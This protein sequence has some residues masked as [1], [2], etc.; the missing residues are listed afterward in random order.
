VYFGTDFNDV[1]DAS[2]DNPMDVL[3]SE[4]QDANT[5]DPGLLEFG[6]TYYWRVDEVNAPPDPIVSKGDIWSFTVEPLAYKI[7][8]ESITATASSQYAD[9]RG[10]EN[11]INESGL[12]PN[13]LDLHSTE[14]EAMWLTGADDTAPV[15][16]QYEFDR[17]YKL[18]QMLVWNYNGEFVL[19]GYGLKDVNVEYS[20]DGQTW[21]RLA[22]VNQ[23]DPATGTQDYK[24]NT[25]VDF[26]NVAARFVKITASSNWN[27][28]FPQ[29]GLSEV[30][31]L[32][33]PVHARESYPASGASDISVDVTFNWRSGREAVEHIVSYST[34]MQA[35]EDNNA[36]VDTISQTSYGPL[37]LDL[38]NIYYW[39][40]DEVNNAEMPTTWLGDIWSFSTQEYILVEDF[41]FYTDDEPNRIWDIWSDGWDDNNNGSTIGHSDPD[42]DAGEHFV[43]TEIVHGGSQSGPIFYD[44]SSAFMSEVSVSISDLA[45]GSDWSS[46]SPEILVLWFYGNPN[47]TPADMYLKINGKKVSYKGD[48]DNL[49][50]QRWSQLSIELSEFDVDIDSITTLAIGFEKTTTPAVKSM[51]FVDNIRLYREAP[52]ITE[53]VDPGSESLVASYL[54]ENNVQDSSGNGL[55]GTVVGAPVFVQGKASLGTAI[56][57]NGTNDYIDCGNNASFDITEAITVSAWVNTSDSGNGEHNPFV[58]KGDHSYAIKHADNNS[59]QFFIYDGGWITANAQVDSSFDGDWHHVAG[60]FDGSEVKLYIDGGIR[61]T[62]AH[63]GT[64]ETSIHNLTIG[65]NSEEVSRFYNGAIDEVRIYNRALSEGE[66]LYL[67]NQ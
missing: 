31:F 21:A 8:Y 16:I 51:V 43:E 11:T 62:T 39:R 67:S 24:Y 12:D 10:P 29:F 6:Q 49:T 56:E 55:H 7:P 53:P 25:I 4:G 33:I 2:L 30:R 59:I 9:N 60:T 44:N 3:V 64:I 66:I 57:L 50:R 5:Y 34:N 18:H 19:W 61:A 65:T 63:V 15:W 1:S 13:N 45:I 14:S 42:F 17:I 22:D 46:G 20:E 28:A 48:P 36:I 37:S 41:E 27:E 40:I 35:I 52:P 38:G 23:L 26:N 32:Y 47:N 54:M 58:A